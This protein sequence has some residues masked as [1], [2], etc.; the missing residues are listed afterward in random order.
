[1]DFDLGQVSVNAPSLFNLSKRSSTG[2]G[3]N[4]IESRFESAIVGSVYHDNAEKLHSDLIGIEETPA[5]DEI[6]DKHISFNSN[7]AFSSYT[8]QSQ[9]V[10]INAFKDSTKSYISLDNIGV[11]EGMYAPTKKTI[12]FEGFDTLQP[13]QSKSNKFN[14][15]QVRNLKKFKLCLNCRKQKLS[16]NYATNGK[17]ISNCR[18]N[19]GQFHNLVFL[20]LY[21]NYLALVKNALHLISF[22]YVKIRTRKTHS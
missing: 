12:F 8:T 17:H 2:E 5:D 16:Y 20:I 14:G 10:H 13:Q 11:C 19:G 22:N 9:Q 1:M 7:K 6:D 3:S 18:F 21:A 4:P 15:K